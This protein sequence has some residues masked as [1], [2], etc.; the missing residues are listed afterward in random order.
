MPTTISMVPITNELAPGAFGLVLE[1]IAE[2]AHR[3]G[4][5]GEQPEEVAIPG[6]GG[7]AADLQPEALARELNPIAEEVHDHRRQRTEVQRD[8]EI[9]AVEFRIIPTEQARNQGKVRGAADRQELGQT[10]NDR[11]NDD[12]IE[13]HRGEDSIVPHGPLHPHPGR[14]GCN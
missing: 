9:E 3:D 7:I 4:G 10:L 1:E 11:H 8:V 2:D 5:G 13:G 14:Y 12:L 6:D